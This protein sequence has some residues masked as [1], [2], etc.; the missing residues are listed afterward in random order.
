MDPVWRHKTAS[1]LPLRPGDKILDICTGTADL[2]LAFANEQ[3]RCSVTAIDISKEMLE[4]ADLKI[5]SKNADNRIELLQADALDLPFPESSFDVC[6]IAFGLRN[7]GDL[8]KGLAEMRRVTKNKGHILILEF[9]PVPK[10][11]ANAPVRFYLKRLVPAIGKLVSKNKKAYKY[12]SASIQ[13][14][15]SPKKMKILIEECGFCHVTAK[16]LMGTFVWLYK[17]Q[18]PIQ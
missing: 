13:S 9:S 3:P 4:L 6:G 8:K 11:L 18:K 7:L 2:A 12:L 16:P 15:L 5:R 1:E 14:F 10:D 17:A